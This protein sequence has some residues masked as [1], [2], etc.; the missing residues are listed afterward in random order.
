LLLSLPR[1][2]F[3]DAPSL[4][5]LA[6]GAA[7]LLPYLLLPVIP[8]TDLPNALAR[9][10]ILGSAP[11]APIRSSFA[12][13][14]ALMPDLG[15]DLVYMALKPIASA[16][17]V[18]RLC[19]VGAMAAMLALV[20]AIQR[21]LFGA[22]SYAAA[23]APL[24]ICGLPVVLGFVNFV[25]S[26]AVVMLGAWLWL[27]WRGELVPARLLALA[28]VAGTAWLCHFAGYVTLM[29]FL[30]CA[31][32]WLFWQAPRIGTAARRLLELV[33]V[34]LPGVVMSAFAEH[35]TVSSSTL[36]YRLYAVRAVFAPVLATGTAA[37]FLL[38]A[39]IVVVCVVVL[40]LGR[41]HVARPAQASLGI[42]LLVVAALPW[43][44]G[45]ATD[46]GSRLICPVAL[47]LLAVSRVTPPPGVWGARAILGILAVLIAVRDAALTDLALH[48]ARSVS[49]FRQAAHGLP[50]GTTLLQATD[51][52]RAADCS[53]AQIPFS[54]IGPATHLAAYA[55]IDRAV[56]EPF[57]FAARG[58]QPIESTRDFA[59]G[60]LRSLSPPGLNDLPTPGAAKTQV[61]A[62][63]DEVPRGWPDRFAYL[64][65]NGRGCAENPMPGLLAPMADGPGFSLYR[66][67]PK[68]AR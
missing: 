17:A 33:A 52:W 4:F 41:W 28:F 13:H 43:G 57:I 66:I 25:M 6:G 31:Q 37:D 48:D 34:A 23:M 8:G 10:A 30:A 26:E 65:V 2:R 60:E 9:L 38:W 68:A 5:M 1:A 54:A 22:V 40:C 46:V 7:V 62:D 36:H 67:I 14:W 3:F 59:K 15:L 42:M 64:L 16:D 55:V 29:L 18:L 53:P 35:E 20:W 11:D 56:W 19:L 12:P 58:K 61:A 44:V 45:A 49:A 21:T 39:G 24:F 32:G 50:L 63:D 47:L 51:K 27:R